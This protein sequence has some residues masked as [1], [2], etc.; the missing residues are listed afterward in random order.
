M[1]GG[2][3]H[4]RRI[5]V[6]A[7]GATALLGA[8]VAASGAQDP[9]GQADSHRAFTA[10]QRCFGAAARAHKQ[11]CENPNLQFSVIPSPSDALIEPS[12]P[13]T[14][15]ISSE[16]PKRCTFGVS[17][18]RSSATVA[19]VGDSHSVH[20][21]AALTKVARAKRWQAVSVYQT[22]CPYTTAK[23]TIDGRGPLGVQ[24]AQWKQDVLRWFQHHPEIHTMFVSQNTTAR[25]AVRNRQ[26]MFE[27]KVKGYMSAWR[28]LPASVRHIVVIRDP[29]HN[30]NSTRSCLERALRQHRRPAAAC[31]RPRTRALEPDA[32]IVAAARAATPRVRAIDL[33]QFMCDS[34]LCYPVVGGVLV[35]KDKGHL[36]RL[37]STSLGPFLLRRVNA[38]FAHW[39]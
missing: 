13:C 31:A 38:L 3:P 8:G 39:R 15:V 22:R 7:V 23:T 32:A 30:L 33:T 18:A 10:K 12:A 17:S 27:A 28:G 36:T 24:C 1:F 14:P 29:P 34:K 2:V 11:P 25:V 5:S 37:F 9:S 16:P 19:L 21:R 6:A 35:H 4:V 26:D 20:W